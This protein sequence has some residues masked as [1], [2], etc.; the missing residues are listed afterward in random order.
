MQISDGR[1]IALAYN[2]PRETAGAGAHAW[3]SFDNAAVMA[4]NMAAYIARKHPQLE[5]R[6]A[7]N[8]ADFARE[9]Q[10]LGRLFKISLADCETRVIYHIGHNAF[11]SLAADYNLIFKPLAGAVFEAEPSPRQTAAMIKEIKAKK[12]KYIFTEEAISPALARAVAAETGARL[13]DLYTIEH[14]TKKDFDEGVTYKQ[15]MIK[16]LENLTKGLSCA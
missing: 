5:R 16:N 4:E 2:L 14:I 11:D 8:A 3:L 15:F 1:A 7:Q 13:L 9:T 6:L 10:M 12:I